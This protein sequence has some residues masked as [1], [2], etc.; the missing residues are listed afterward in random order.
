MQLT[1]SELT[2]PEPES[3]AEKS[4]GRIWSID[5]IVYGGGGITPDV[6]VP[7]EAKHGEEATLL[8]MQSGLVSYFVFEQLDTNRKLF[9]SL[10]K[11][12]LE[13]EIKTMRHILSEKCKS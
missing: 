6:F 12:Q 5:R 9:N 11:T 3:L 13:K 1:K 10:S 4:Q 8:I 7:F 2:G